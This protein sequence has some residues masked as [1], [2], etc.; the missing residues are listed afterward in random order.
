[1]ISHN[2]IETMGQPIAVAVGGSTY[3]IKARVHK[4]KKKEYTEDESPQGIIVPYLK[5][6]IKLTDLPQR[7]EPG[8]KW[9]VRFNEVD[10]VFTEVIDHDLTNMLICNLSEKTENI[11]PLSEYFNYG[12]F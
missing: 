3:S 6:Y 7:P 12:T 1:M 2:I 4:Y 9:V 5:L 10:Y 8:D 11:N